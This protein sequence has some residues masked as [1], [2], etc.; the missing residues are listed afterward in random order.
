MHVEINVEM[1]WHTHPRYT[2]PN[3]TPRSG[4]LLVF[5]IYE[6][7][8]EGGRGRIVPNSIL[9]VVLREIRF[10]TVFRRV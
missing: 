10:G 4:R 8:P 6:P 1:N 5:I 7:R 9:S 3:T 2:A